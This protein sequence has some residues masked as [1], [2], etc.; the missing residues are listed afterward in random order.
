[1]FFELVFL[2]RIARA[3]TRASRTR[4]GSSEEISRFL[5]APLRRHRDWT[6]NEPARRTNRR[7]DSPRGS[8]RASLLAS[9]SYRI[10]HPEDREKG[11][12]KRVA[13]PS[14]RGLRRIRISR[15]SGSIVPR[16]SSRLS[17]FTFLSFF[18]SYATRLLAPFLLYFSRFVRTSRRKLYRR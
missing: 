18:L 3:S 15:S 4:Q 11:R 16:P 5:P 7:D 12:E 9:S 6:V 10:G 8:L 2:S 13:L 17:L 14:V 1:M